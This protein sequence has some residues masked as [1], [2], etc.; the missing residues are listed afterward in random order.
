MK[1]HIKIRYWK[2]RSYQP[3]SRWQHLVRAMGQLCKILGWSPHFLFNQHTCELLTLEILIKC[4]FAYVFLSCCLFAHTLK[5]F[6]CWPMMKGILQGLAER[7]NKEQSQGQNCKKLTLYVWRSRDCTLKAS[8]SHWCLQQGELSDERSSFKRLY[9]Y[10][11][12]W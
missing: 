4:T 11:K 3:M 9:W 7:D 8:E 2:V 10:H 12:G 5:H 1:F 6:N